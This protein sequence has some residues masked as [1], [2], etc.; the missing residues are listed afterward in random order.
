MIH[1]RKSNGR[2]PLPHPIPLPTSTRILSVE[3]ALT[4][5]DSPIRTKLVGLRS[6]QDDPQF[7]DGTVYR[8]VST[9]GQDTKIGTNDPIGY[10]G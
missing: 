9:T 10:G 8:Q 4:H 2:R 1:C 6:S 3:F 7:K 5:S